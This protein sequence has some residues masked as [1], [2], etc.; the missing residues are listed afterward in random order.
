MIKLATFNIRCDYNQDGINCFSN[1]KPLILKKIIQEQP[2]VICFQEVLPHV[3]VWLKENLTDY[4]IIGCG[5]SSSLEDEQTSIAYQKGKY[6]LI[7]ME[8]FW[9]S[10][11][12]SQ[13][14]SR[15]PQQ[16]I[17]PRAC[18]EAV[19]QNLQTK[20][21]F[22]IINIHLD[23]EG[24]KARLLGLG[25]IFQKLK[26]EKGFH[27]IPVILAGDFNAFPDSEE[28]Q[29][30][31]EYPR[32]HDMTELAGGTFHDYGNLS[33]PEKIDYIYAEDKLCSCGIEKWMDC[34][35]GVYLSDHYPL[36]VEM[37]TK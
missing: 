36:C 23:H 18:T 19:L 25:Q 27:D 6:N 31:K 15:Y 11:T 22:R 30:M 17:C 13:P 28:M 3:A 2:H 34:S 26:A 20:E 35:E 37:Y 14:G 7:S 8:T 10:E 9:L 5:R 4:Y 12:P 24:T 21:L 33:E 29:V 32:F 16:S 1:R